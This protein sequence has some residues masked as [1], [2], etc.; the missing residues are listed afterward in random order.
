MIVLQSAAYA[1]AALKP[2]LR[3]ACGVRALQ[4]RF[5]NTCVTRMSSIAIKKSVPPSIFYVFRDSKSVSIGV[6]P[7][8]IILLLQNEPNF[9]PSTLRPTQSNPVQ[10]NPSILRK[11]ELVTPALLFA[12]RRSYLAGFAS[13]ARLRPKSCGNQ[14]GTR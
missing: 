3:E 12:L 13:F 14:A 6:Y 9:E 7:W 8:L 10:P 1:L 4:R 11:N 5:Q 2:D